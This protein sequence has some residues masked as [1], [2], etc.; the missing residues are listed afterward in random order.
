MSKASSLPRS[1]A[2]KLWKTPNQRA[3]STPR[4]AEALASPGP[5][6]QLARLCYG[7]GQNW[8]RNQLRDPVSRPYLIDV[9]QGGHE[10]HD[11]SAIG[12]VDHA[13]VGEHTFGRHG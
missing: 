7:S 11:L 1:G 4:T 3:P 5:A 9:G 8:G 6:R 13:G 10:H 2:T 12:G